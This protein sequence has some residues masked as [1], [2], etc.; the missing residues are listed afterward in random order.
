LW[1]LRT[2]TTNE[3]P[4]VS[5]L[6]VLR[7]NILRIVE[8]PINSKNFVEQIQPTKVILLCVFDVWIHRSIN[9][10]PLQN[11]LPVTVP[12]RRIFPALPTM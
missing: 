9:H 7:R 8:S 1:V 11:A 5:F 12:N 4:T 10:F 3:N 6:H 2:T